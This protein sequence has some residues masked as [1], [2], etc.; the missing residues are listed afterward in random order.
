MSLQ[1]IFSKNVR[2]RNEA[3]HQENGKPVI[4]ICVPMMGG[5]AWESEKVIVVVLLQLLSCVPIC[6][7]GVQQRAFQN[8][9]RAEKSRKSES[10]LYVNMPTLYQ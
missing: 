9:W 5:R 4:I 1:N 7:G 8:F 3:P 6:T 10:D 2:G